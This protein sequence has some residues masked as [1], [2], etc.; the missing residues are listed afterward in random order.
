MKSRLANVPPGAR[1][2][3]YDKWK[4]SLPMAAY[5]DREELEEYNR[6]RQ[7]EE[8]KQQERRNTPPSKKSKRRA[9]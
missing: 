2:I 1:G 5:Y 6:Q 7:A 8:T 3:P 9:K 4:A